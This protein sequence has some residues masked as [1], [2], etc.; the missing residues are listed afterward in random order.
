MLLTNWARRFIPKLVGFTS[1]DDIHFPLMSGPMNDR[2]VR[3]FVGLGGKVVRA[4]DWRP[5]GP[6]FESW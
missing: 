6:G 5:R 2:H 3:M 1:Y 4:Q